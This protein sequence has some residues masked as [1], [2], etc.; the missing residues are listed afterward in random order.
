VKEEEE[1]APVTVIP[2]SAGATADIP[3]VSSHE[4]HVAARDKL[5]RRT[6]RQL[7]E[8]DKDSKSES[9]G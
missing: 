7:D 4:T 8:S 3:D 5:R 6:S 2:S 9:E 1:E